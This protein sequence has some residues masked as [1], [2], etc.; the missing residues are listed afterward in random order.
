MS[1][2]DVVSRTADQ[3]HEY[4]DP[5]SGKL[6]ATVTFHEQHEPRPFRLLFEPWVKGVSTSWHK[7][8]SRVN[9]IVLNVHEHMI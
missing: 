9:E 5:A 2:N 7:D 3:Q 4:V 1:R 8:M 6:M